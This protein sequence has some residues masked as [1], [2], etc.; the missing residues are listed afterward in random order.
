MTKSNFNVILKGRYRSLLPLLVLC[1][2]S[3]A[4]LSNYTRVSREVLQEDK[5]RV[6]NEKP[7]I[8]IP[9][10]INATSVV[11]VQRQ[12]RLV[13][14]TT[15]TTNAPI[16]TPDDAPIVVDSVVISE[17]QVQQEGD[18]KINKEQASPQPP[19]PTVVVEPLGVQDQE[20]VTTTNAPTTTSI[21]SFSS[22]SAE[23]CLSKRGS[24]GRWILDWDYAATA[25]YQTIGS[26]PPAVIA[27]DR[28]K[29]TPEEPFRRASAFKWQDDYAQD[30]PFSLLL[31]TP[32]GDRN[33]SL[34]DFCRTCQMLNID[35]IWVAGDSLSEAFSHSLRAQL[36]FFYHAYL[37]RL[38]QPFYITCPPLDNDNHNN[39]NTNSTPYTILHRFDRVDEDFRQA[40]YGN[41]MNVKSQKLAP[42]RRHFLERQSPHIIEN[43][44]SGHIPEGRGRT[45]MILNIGVH[46]HDH[47]NY[48]SSFAKI[49]NTLDKFYNS[50][51]SS[52][53]PSQQPQQ[54][55]IVWFRNTSP[56]HQGCLPKQGDVPIPLKKYA[57]HIP[58]DEVPFETYADYEPTITDQFDWNLIPDFNQYAQDHLPNVAPTRKVATFVDDND[59]D[60]TLKNVHYLN[61]FN[62]T[63]LRRDGHVGMGD[64]LHYYYPG[65]IDW[66][67]HLWFS[68]LKDMAAE[69]AAAANTHQKATTMTQQS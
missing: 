13:T 58:I 31:Q 18:N 15:A 33:A 11:R 62:M 63:V 26:M 55:P 56:G 57:W 53:T 6:P 20:T 29:P 40:L 32:E 34:A 64:C 42:Q 45:A 16:T 47:V 22:K 35:Q 44:K 69:A 30:C 43:Y 4:L 66:Q 21:S 51:S 2:T 9:I 27:N 5:R 65:P 8:P 36:G 59:N 49:W 1:V 14:D 24:S 38:I 3:G 10:P 67:V 60:N 61:I 39:N 52:T 46:F 23:Y 28:Y 12:N 68:S 25:Q 7:T 19:P 50:S 17:E 41:V 37:L 48:T 54:R